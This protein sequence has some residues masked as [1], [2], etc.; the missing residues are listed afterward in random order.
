MKALTLTQPWATLVMVGA[1][2]VETRG[3][4]TR[5]RGPLAIHAAAGWSA[6]DRE[7]AADL[8][9]AGILPAGWLTTNRSIKP[10]LPL[11]R[12]LGIVRLVDVIPTFALAEYAPRTNIAQHVIGP[13]EREYGDYSHGRFAWLLADVEAF[14]APIPARGALGLWDWVGP[15]GEPAP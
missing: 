8:M 7:F 1:K 4:P 3:W 2:Q 11:G 14:P 5:Y 10:D 15:E 12:V 6:D 13:L 9:D